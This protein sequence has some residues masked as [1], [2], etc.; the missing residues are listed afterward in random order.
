MEAVRIAGPRFLARK[1]VA[2][3]VEQHPGMCMHWKMLK[4]IG[5]VAT[6]LESRPE[7]LMHQPKRI[8]KEVGEP[9]YWATEIVM[10]DAQ[11]EYLNQQSVS[12]T[13]STHGGYT[14]C[15]D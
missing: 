4:K 15:C 7:S 3:A 5:R 9:W 6:E 10:A 2:R 8:S 12:Q 1:D 13:L 14:S 11:P